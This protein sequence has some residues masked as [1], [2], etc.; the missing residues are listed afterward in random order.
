M[1]DIC[2]WLIVYV[3]GDFSFWWGDMCCPS[4]S[5]FYGWSRFICYLVFFR[6][7][8]IYFQ[9]WVVWLRNL[10]VVCFTYMKNIIVFL[11]KLK[12]YFSSHWTYWT[13]YICSLMLLSLPALISH[14][15][16]KNKYSCYL[17]FQV[18]VH[19][20]V[21]FF[22]CVSFHRWFSLIFLRFSDL[23]GIVFILKLR[24]R[25]SV[26]ISHGCDTR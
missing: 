6:Y 10:F 7:T 11:P 22:V 3:R 15:I 19:L 20:R 17:L 25:I 16:T 18:G 14:S 8:V 12:E 23:F 26:S 5:I 4:L 24:G 9:V 21:P 2:K 13:S 1:P